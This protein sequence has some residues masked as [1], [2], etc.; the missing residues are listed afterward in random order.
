M[1]GLMRKSAPALP[2][3]DAIKQVADG[4]MTLID[5]RDHGELTYSGKAKGALHIPM[6]R[7]ADMADPRHPDFHP[8]LDISKPVGLYC[9]SGARSHMA[10]GLM[11]RLGYEN[12]HN[13]GGL[14][15]WVAA[16]GA[17]EKA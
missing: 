3:A 9:A 5:I 12:V 1:F 6:M 7:L 13:L 2:V 15:H 11:K 10:A 14:G 8:E 16:G 4:Q 17:V